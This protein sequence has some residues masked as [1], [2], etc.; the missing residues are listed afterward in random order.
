MPFGSD[1]GLAEADGDAIVFP[2]PLGEGETEAGAPAPSRPPP[3][4]DAT[5]IPAATSTIAPISAQNGMGG[6]LRVAAAQPSGSAA[7]TI[8]RVRS[9][10]SAIAATSASTVS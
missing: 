8:S 3:M 2:A 9:T 1:D 5:I 7:G 6:L 10:S 4:A